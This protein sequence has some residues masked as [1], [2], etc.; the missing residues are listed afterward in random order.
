MTVASILKQKSDRL[1]SVKEA[2][3]L[4]D[5]AQILTRENIGAVPVLD[6]GGDMVGIISERDIVRQ[7]ARDGAGVLMQPVGKIMT[8]NVI[9][10]GP[11]DSVAATMAMMTARRF[12][13]LPVRSQNKIV[14]MISIGDLVKRRVEDA[15][16]EAEE[17]REYIVRG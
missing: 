2:D 4:A 14:G 13:H 7:I 11:D 1:I 9:C 12:R 16:R 10:C 6:S 5:V 8:R 15:E 3:S 17:L